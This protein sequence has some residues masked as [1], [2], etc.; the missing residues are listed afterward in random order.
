MGGSINADQH[1]LRIIDVWRDLIDNRCFMSKQLRY[2]EIT[3][4]SPILTNYFT[5]RQWNHVTGFLRVH[6]LIKWV[7][8]LKLYCEKTGSYATLVDPPWQKHMCDLVPWV[9]MNHW[10]NA[11]RKPL[12]FVIPQSLSLSIVDV[13]VIWITMWQILWLGWKLGDSL[14]H[15]DW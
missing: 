8:N 14:F 6:D 1:I 5:H 2:F 3:F 7:H 10:W 13:V 15:D 11:S 9:K 12:D 4:F